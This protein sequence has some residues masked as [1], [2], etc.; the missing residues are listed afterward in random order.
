MRVEKSGNFTDI[1][2]LTVTIDGKDV[3]GFAQQ[4]TIYQ[5]IF[6]PCWTAI[7]TIEDSANILMNIPIKPGSKVTIEVETETESVL[8]GS[9]S[10]DFII[11]KLGDKAFKGQ[12]HYQY[13]LYCA[14]QGFLTN[15]TNRISKTYSNQKPED[16][17]SNVF[18]EFLGGSLT[19]SD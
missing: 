14:S 5:D 19:K 3:S 12:M 16:S 9:K 6:L 8:D 4:T 11:Y 2:K 7:I 17:V 18:S 1:K 10:Y 13:K 15:Q